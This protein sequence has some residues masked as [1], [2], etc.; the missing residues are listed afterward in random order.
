MPKSVHIDF[1]AYTDV[2]R[3]LNTARLPCSVDDWVR[4]QAK[5]LV[6]KFIHEGHQSGTTYSLSLPS[7][8]SLRVEVCPT[9]RGYQVLFV[10]IETA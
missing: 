4:S 9:A 2:L 6:K 5:A 8:Q 10:A 3:Y 7:D 1:Q